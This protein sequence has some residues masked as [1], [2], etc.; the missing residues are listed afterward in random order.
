LLIAFI[1]FVAE[2][3]YWSDERCSSFDDDRGWNGLRVLILM[4]IN[5][6]KRSKTMKK[7]SII[8]SLVLI[9]ATMMLSGCIFP[10]WDDE[11]GRHHGGGHSEGGYRD[12][13][14]H[15]G[16]ERH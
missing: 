4:K 14:H 1:A 3:E 12:G 11:G 10:Y 7:S 8:S 5:I 13:G 2:R 16:G 6:R 15:E 9:V